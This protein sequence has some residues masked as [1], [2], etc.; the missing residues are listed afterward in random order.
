M[1]SWS[2]KKQKH[3]TDSSC[4]AEYIALH[5]ANKE[6]V[7]LRE[8]LEGLGFPPD[9]STPLKCDNDAA[10]RLVGDQSNHA[11]VKH[12][13]VKYHTTRDLVDEGI[14]HIVR[15]PSADNVADIFTK[16][17]A[18]PAFIKFRDLLGL[19]SSESPSA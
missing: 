15:I 7:F 12:F 18:K 14:V 16:A 8:L 17:L 9:V 10:R 5:H 3:A 6:T 11:N 2:S 1:I 13:R 19:K 4:Y